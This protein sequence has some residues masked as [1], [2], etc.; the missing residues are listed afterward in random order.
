MSK[1]S[2]LYLLILLCTIQSF[3][4]EPIQNI[5]SRNNLSLNG[6]WNYMIDP[7]ETGYYDYRRVPFDQS[8][9]KEGGFYDNRAQTDKSELL[10]YDF[11]HSQTLNVPGDW[12]SQAEKLS[13][14]E[15]N[16]WYKRSFT[17]KPEKDKQYLLYFAAVSYEAHVYLNGKKLGLHRGGFTPFQYDV[18]NQLRD[19]ANFV[20][21]KV[22]NTRKKEA[23]PTIATDWWN[24]GGIT[25]DVY[26]TALPKTYICDY[27]VQL[28]KGNLKLIE[29][30]VQLKGNQKKQRL[31]VQIPEAGLLLN[32]QTDTSGY[33]A[34]HI[35]VKMLK[36]WSPEIPK[37][38]V[39]KISA[40]TDQ[41]DDQIGFRTIETKGQDI[42]LNGKPVFLRGISMHDENPLIPGRPRS[43]GDLKML[44][45]W[46]KELNCNFVRLAHYPHNEEMIRLADKM[47]LLVWAEIP[48]Y[49]TIDWENQETYKNAEQQLSDL[50]TRDKNRASVI[51]WSVG[52]ETPLSDPR[53]KFMS[54]LAAKA[55]SLDN[56]RLISAAL[57]LH[58]EGTSVIVDDVLS[59]K[60]DL[61]SF[62]EYAGW[63]WGGTPKEI[64]KYS[65]KVKY[66]KPVIITEFGG[67]AL[68]GFHGDEDTR[69]TEEYQDALYKS[70]FRI[71]QSIEGLRGMTPWILVDFRS[72]R[73]T[74][75]V[76][77]DFWNRKGLISETG[78][79]KKAFFTLKAH[80]DQLAKKYP[81][82]KKNTD[83][84]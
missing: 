26:L 67:D 10:E 53:L 21:V 32:L 66:K 60:L 43:A 46:A 9:T 39:V 51:I 84:L 38:Y 71:Q 13:L 47:G 5:G 63:Y 48:V 41:V 34:I 78:K 83:A 77:Q 64:T 69:W 33:A 72:P 8:K 29:G 68:A 1:F 40:E 31:K 36:Y 16:I 59:E 30:Y 19:G 37:L 22:D 52:N 12:N 58:R 45:D 11:D 44:L 82:L 57:E 25:R 76:Y 2:I 15:G 42:L 4:Q 17:V 54:G 62:N 50:I 28:A 23:I 18:S 65:F 81:Y 7:Y 70:Q 24:Y 55:R 35:P 49:W 27:K 6:K 79:K 75:P 73:R 80:Y 61:V 20:V 74:H 56:T 3:A 14:Y